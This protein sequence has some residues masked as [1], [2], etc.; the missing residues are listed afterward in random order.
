MR[1]WR[2]DLS[3]GGVT[4][5]GR[6]TKDGSYYDLYWFYPFNWLD[7]GY[8]YWGRDWFYYDGPH[9]SF[10]FWFFNVTWRTA[11][12]EWTVEPPWEKTRPGE[13]SAPDDELKASATWRIE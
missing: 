2:I 3:N 4:W 13:G 7:K 8:R 12:T 1:I 10:G 6:N 5:L 9:P 11:W